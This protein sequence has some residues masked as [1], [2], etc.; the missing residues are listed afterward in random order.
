MEK[1]EK[2]EKKEKKRPCGREWCPVG[3][4]C[5]ALQDGGVSVPRPEGVCGA[6]DADFLRS[7]A[8]GEGLAARLAG[9]IIEGLREWEAD[10]EESALVEKIARAYRAEFDARLERWRRMTA[11]ARQGRRLTDLEYAFYTDTIQA[12]KLGI[13]EAEKDAPV[14]RIV[15]ARAVFDRFT[16]TE[17]GLL[18]DRQMLAVVEHLAANLADGTPAL[19]TGDKGIAKTQAARFAAGL[20]SA[21]PLVISGHGDLMSDVFTGRMEQDPASGIFR[22]RL[23]AFVEAACEGRPVLLDE[24]NVS[25]QTIVMRLQDYLLTR[26]GGLLTVQES[27]QPAYQV[28]PGFA[29][30]ATA[31]EASGRYRDRAP[32]DPAFRDRF[33]VIKLDYPDVDPQEDPL[34]HLPESLLRLAL[35]CCVDRTGAVSP[36]IDLGELETFARL[37]YVTEYL[38]SVPAKDAAL[39]FTEAALAG[40]VFL[41]E[42]PAMTD[43]ITPRALAAMVKRCSLGNNGMT[44]R[45]E[46]RRAIAA[47][48]QAAGSRSN[49]D[50]AERALSLLERGE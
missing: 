19:L 18:F 24:V 50:L 35:A 41:D 2:K 20:F 31:N 27:G 10:A 48:D 4:Y 40:S 32:L 11:A 43:C 9:G 46:M 44:L 7:L 1:I 25:D 29:V 47:L 28:K 13:A 5:D 16:V 34:K 26:P 45:G 23:G 38:Y 15:R 22:H 42:E 8:Q 3:H 14:E 17:Y 6:E 21:A 36:H 49:R 30:F 37:S 12:A 33:D 39:P